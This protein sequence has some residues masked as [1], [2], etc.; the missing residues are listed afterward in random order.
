MCANTTH[1]MTRTDPPKVIMVGLASCF[2]CQVQITNVE[3]HLLDILSQIDLKYW[4]LAMSEPMPDEFDIAVIEGAVTTQESLQ[5]VKEIRE[6]AKVVIA[7]GAC[8]N[9]A[10]LP[11]MA[12][13]DFDARANEVYAGVP[14][15]CGDMISPRS[16]PSV[17]EVDYQVPSCPIDPLEFLDALQAALYGS[18]KAT[19]TQTMCGECKR[20]ETEC[21]YAKGQV[22][23]GLVTR[24]GCGALCVQHNRPCNGCRGISPDANLD[25]ARE[26]VVAH[27]LSEVEFIK[28]LEMFNQTDPILPAGHVAKG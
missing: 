20:S 27:G 18:N 6:K 24:G 21:F 11:G 17:I 2:G 15:V 10:G 25:S 14:L 3:V 9:T 12:A 19:L 7:I 13:F 28:S 16:V 23:L 5:T 4:Q 22:C 1:Q 8:A 26:I